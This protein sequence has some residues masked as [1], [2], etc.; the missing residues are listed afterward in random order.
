MHHEA[1]ERPGGAHAVNLRHQLREEMRGQIG[2]N[3]HIVFAEQHRFVSTKF[4]R[5]MTGQILVGV[6]ITLARGVV[7]GGN[8]VTRHARFQ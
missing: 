8:L 6:A 2:G 1:G 4:A 3:K 5:E 7:D